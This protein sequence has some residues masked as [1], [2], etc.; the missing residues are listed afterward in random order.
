MKRNLCI[1]RK[2]VS[3]LL[4]IALL[5]TVVSVTLAEDKNEDHLVTMD[6]HLN[7]NVMV[8]RYSVKAYIDDEYLDLLPQGGR[9]IKVLELPTGIHTLSFQGEKSSVPVMSFDFYVG[10]DI[11]MEAT[12]QTH[13]KYINVNELYVSLPDGKV[14]KFNDKNDDWAEF[15][16]DLVKMT[17]VFD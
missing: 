5:T 7:S 13:R 16:A 10:Y 1:V 9:I 8:A 12:L 6:L 4:L 17:G 3:V 2:L 14:L 11:G 15:I